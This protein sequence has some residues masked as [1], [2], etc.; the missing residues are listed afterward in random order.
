MMDQLTVMRRANGELFTLTIKGR[1]HLAMW[2]SLESAERYKF[3]NPDLLVFKPASVASAFG[4][5]SLKPLKED[6]VELFLLVDAGGAH[7]GDGRKISWDE[8]EGSFATD[9][10]NPTL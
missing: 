9:R 5:K 7:F 8:F 4:Q 6:G 2:P 3:R 10:G 1:Q